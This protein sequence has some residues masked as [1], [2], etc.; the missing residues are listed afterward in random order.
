MTILHAGI[1]F[2]SAEQG[3][4]EMHL[5]DDSHNIMQ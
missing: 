4:Q 1:I 3:T 5:A 2:Q